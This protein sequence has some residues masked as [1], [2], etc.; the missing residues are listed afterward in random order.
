MELVRLPMVYNHNVHIKLEVDIL[1]SRTSYAILHS[2][3]IYFSMF[4]G[5]ERES[6]LREGV[7]EVEIV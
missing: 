5:A 7:G 3:S 1:K 2:V 6:R 4:T